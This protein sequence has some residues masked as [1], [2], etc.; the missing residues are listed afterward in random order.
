MK[1]LKELSRKMLKAHIDQTDSS[2]E[3]VIE[4]GGYEKYYWQD[5]WRYRE[6]LLLLVWRDILVRYK[7]TVFGV[8]WAVIKPVVTMVVFTVIFGRLVNLT[9][10]DIPYPLLVFGGVLAWQFFSTSLTDAANSVVGNANMIS[11]IYFPRM[12]VPLGVLIVGLVDFAITLI[13]FAA[14]AIWFDYLPSWHVLFFPF[15]VGLLFLFSFATALWFAALNVRYR[16]FRYVLPFL[17]QLG[18]YASPVG[19]SSSIVP[20][21]WQLIYSFN[22]MVGIIDGFR[23]SLF[24]SNAPLNAFSVWVAIILTLMLLIFGIRFFRKQERQFADII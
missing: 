8:A 6:L 12:I 5:I 24:R 23:W 1:P 4:A 11:K 21:E 18:S 19:F 7:Q 10:H 13:V 20:V 14:L 3:I 2:N 17:L 22:P 16:D 15:F 9:S